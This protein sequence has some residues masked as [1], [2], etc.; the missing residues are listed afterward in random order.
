MAEKLSCD[1]EFHVNIGRDEAAGCLPPVRQLM[2]IHRRGTLVEDH[3]AN[4]AQFRQTIGTMDILLQPSWTESF[5]MVTAD[6]VAE[7]VASAVLESVDWV[8]HSWLAK[9][10]DTSSL[11][12]TGISL[13]FNPHAPGEGQKALQHYVT[14]GTR[15]WLDFLVS[16]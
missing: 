6:G 14:T 13:L 1:V 9:L 3:W 2:A 12:T 5:N 15:R 7:G 8:P 11:A 10:D 16:K 4:W